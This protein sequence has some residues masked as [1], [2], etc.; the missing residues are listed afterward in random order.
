M[1][2]ATAR[3]R[4]RRSRR[5]CCARRRS[6]IGIRLSSSVGR[7]P[8]G[9]AFIAT[10]GSTMSYSRSGWRPTSWYMPDGPLYH[11]TVNGVHEGSSSYVFLP[12]LELVHGEELEVKIIIPLRQDLRRNWNLICR[13]NFWEASVSC[14]ALDRRGLYIPQGSDRRHLQTWEERR[15]DLSA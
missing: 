10:T 7:R 8:G 6:T 11:Y 14:G 4:A 1:E 15:H 5:S 12:I 9:S 13:W 3:R 2:K